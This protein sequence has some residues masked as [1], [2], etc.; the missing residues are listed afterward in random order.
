[1]RPDDLEALPISGNVT[2]ATAF[3]LF[4]DVKGRRLFVPNAMLLGNRRFQRGQDVTF[5]LTRGYLKQ[6]GFIA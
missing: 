6:Q 4:L 3:G 1:M 2:L 5:W